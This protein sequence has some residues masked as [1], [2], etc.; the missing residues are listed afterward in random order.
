MSDFTRSKVD[1]DGHKSYCKPCSADRERIRRLRDPSVQKRAYRR[2]AER[3][4]DRIRE[5]NKKRAKYKLDWQREKGQRGYHLKHTYGITLADEEAMRV[6][7]G[8]LCAICQKGR[9]LMVDHDHETGRVRGLLC[10]GCNIALHLFDD[11]VKLKRT[12]AYLGME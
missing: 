10:N 3:H 8:G 11:P 9:S 12:L 4:P 1:K 5:G 2:Y 7:Q 6:Q